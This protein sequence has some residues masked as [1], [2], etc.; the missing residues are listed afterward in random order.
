MQVSLFALIFMKSSLSSA[1]HFGKY[2]QLIHF[3]FLGT[4]HSTFC[5][6]VITD[7][8]KLAAELS[9]RRAIEKFADGVARLHDSQVKNCTEKM[10]NHNVSTTTKLTHF[11]Y[12]KDL[13]RDSGHVF[14]KQHDEK[15]PP[16]AHP[17][18]KGNLRDL[19]HSL[20]RRVHK[21]QIL[22]TQ[23]GKAVV[24]YDLPA[25]EKR[26]LVRTLLCQGEDVV[27]FDGTSVRPPHDNELHTPPKGFGDAPA[28]TR[29]ETQL[30]SPAKRI[31]RQ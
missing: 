2:K 15:L 28:K 14:D 11:E 19:F 21:S 29:P 4:P 6:I 13:L 25:V 18:K 31:K 5:G 10:Y 26:L 7:A 22:R 23:D 16:F 17:P 1:L 8:F 3:L 9:Y 30:Q 24:L 27:I 20:S 12:C